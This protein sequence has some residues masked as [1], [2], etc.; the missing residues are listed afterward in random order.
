MNLVFL[1]LDSAQRYDKVHP[2]GER[3]NKWMHP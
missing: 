3:I 1:M 2:I